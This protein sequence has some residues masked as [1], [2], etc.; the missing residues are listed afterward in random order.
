MLGVSR[1]A[2]DV[3]AFG[4]DDFP[5][6]EGDLDLRGDNSPPLESVTAAA[7]RLRVSASDLCGYGPVPGLVELRE[8]L[9]S[10]FR[11]TASQVVITCGASEAL[12]LT[13]MC[14]TDPGDT[15]RTPRPAFPG[16]DQLASLAGLRIEHYPATSAVPRDPRTAACATI[17]CTP[18]NPTGT[19]TPRSALP[20][21]SSRW[22]IWD[23]SHT[24]LFGE[25]ADEFRRGLTG[26][27]ILVC[28]LSKLLRLPGARLGCL[29]TGSEALVKA[30]VAVKTH[31]SMS[32]GRPGQLLAAEVLRDPATAEC[33]ARRQQALAHQ[34]DLLQQA[35]ERSP[36]L[37]V[38][39]AAGG[40]HLLL[41]TTNGTDAWGVLRHAGLVGLPGVVFHD[42]APSVRL[43]T[44]QPDDVI[45]EAV[46]R[47]RTL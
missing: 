47:I 14:T 42:D 17:V 32:A 35:V 11:L 27:E 38:V 40:T 5:L 10:V 28:S 33:L 22:T 20:P 7:A 12:H 21:D 24:S 18:H 34:R 2:H 37:T 6:R 43:C 25:D 4:Y 8:A 31:V 15:I 23:I 26:T 3:V 13:L 46:N 19:L 44:A 41:G 36:R 29:I 39:P 30:V 1:R 16:F 45:R 9:A